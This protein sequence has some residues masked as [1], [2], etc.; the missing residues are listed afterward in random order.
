M[1]SVFLYSIIINH[2]FS[3]LLH[4]LSKIKYH[5]NFLGN[6]FKINKHTLQLSQYEMLLSARYEKKKFNLWENEGGL[7]TNDLT[8][9]HFLGWVKQ[10]DRP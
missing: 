3:F 2:I 9:H 8:S 1:Y 10:L 7:K 5:N 6:K 4:S